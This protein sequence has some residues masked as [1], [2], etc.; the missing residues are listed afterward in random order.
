MGLRDRDRELS[1]LSSNDIGDKLYR[2]NE[3]PNHHYHKSMKRSVTDTIRDQLD[4]EPDLPIMVQKAYIPSEIHYKW[5]MYI[6]RFDTFYF[7]LNVLIRPTI[8]NL[9]LDRSI[10]I[11]KGI[12]MVRKFFDLR[13]INFQ[14]YMF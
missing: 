14:I 6:Q 1:P 8:K 7:Q 10:K 3:I 4:G 2:D 12:I 11:V 9:N 13:Q 5:C